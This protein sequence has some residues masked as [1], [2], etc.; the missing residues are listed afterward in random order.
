MGL[1]ANMMAYDSAV[2]VDLDGFGEAITYVKYNAA[3]RAINATAWREEYQDPGTGQTRRA[4]IVEV[5]NNAT[6][7]ILPS[8][9]DFD[10]DRITAPYQIGETADTWSLVKPLVSQDPGTIRIRLE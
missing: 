8:E 2:S 4:L 5:R 7:G 9:I 6:L 10:R 1:L 3:T